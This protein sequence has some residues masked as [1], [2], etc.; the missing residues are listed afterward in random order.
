MKRTALTRILT[1]TVAALAF[2]ALPGAAEAQQRACGPHVNS[3][4]GASTVADLERAEVCLINNERAKHG[5]R[6]LRRNA[7][8]SRAARAHT[9]DMI[10]RRYFDHTSPQGR[11]VVDRLLNTGYLKQ[12]VSWVVGENLAWGGQSRGT[13]REILIA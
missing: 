1:P 6:R 10:A 12:V 9:Q 3:R 7:R 2:C 11:D 8:L 13:P 4:P 5:M